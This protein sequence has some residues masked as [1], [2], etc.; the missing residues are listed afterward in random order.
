MLPTEQSTKR[1]DLIKKMYPG[2][3]RTAVIWNG[4]A[5]GHRLQMDAMQL[6]A[7]VL[8]MVLQS[9]P[10]RNVDEIDAGLRAA[11]EANA[12]A[13]VTMDDPLIQSNRV[14]IV[15]FAMGQ[16]LPVMGEFRPF[17][18]AGALMTY[19]PNQIDLW[20]SAAVYVDKIFKG[21]K[22]AD[23]PV[24]QPTKFE[25]LINLKTAKALGFDVPALLLAQAD[26]V[27]E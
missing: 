27:I 20:R 16:R 12:Q 18:E 13:I 6:A 7:P 11:R 14:R 22:P 4:N 1:L 15:E 5:A 17:A 19:A 26:E 2:L 24:Q 3:T 8:G 25:L 10:T 21:A 23:L 9:L